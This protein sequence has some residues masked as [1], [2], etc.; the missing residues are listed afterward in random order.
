MHA[1]I[2]LSQQLPDAYMIKEQLS[3]THTLNSLGVRDGST[4]HLTARLAGGAPAA[5]SKEKLRR[6]SDIKDGVPWCKRICGKKRMEP[7][8]GMCPFVCSKKGACQRT[9]SYTHLTLP[10]IL[11]V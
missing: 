6:S 11:L 4:L 3:T 7:L 2:M 5:Q 1:E 9:V 10:T 8:P